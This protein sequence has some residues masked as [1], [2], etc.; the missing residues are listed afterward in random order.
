MKVTFHAVKMNV[1]CPW[2]WNVNRK[3]NIDILRHAFHYREN[4]ESLLL[5]PP[6][7][8]A[9][10]SKPPSICTVT[11]C[12]SIINKL[13]FHSICHKCK[14]SANLY[15]RPW[16]RPDSDLLGRTVDNSHFIWINVNNL[17]SIP[18]CISLVQLNEMSHY[19]NATYFKTTKPPSSSNCKI[20]R[21]Y[22]ITF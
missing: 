7:P 15:T 8:R 22:L 9:C 1:H 11:D 17:L 5:F 13:F 4:S 2:S 19:K 3:A 12:S 20:I 6:C 16:G 10:Y 21:P 18:S 14:C